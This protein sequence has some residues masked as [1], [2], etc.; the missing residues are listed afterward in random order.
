MS[1]RGPSDVDSTT[2]ENDDEP[3][4][5]ALLDVFLGQSLRKWNSL[6]QILHF[7]VFPSEPVGFFF[8]PIPFPEDL[9]FPRDL[10]FPP[11]N[12]ESYSESGISV[13]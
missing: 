12:I 6:S 4:C 9:F 10:P 8:L 2:A 5:M 3:A 1:P 13:R 11:K 7:I